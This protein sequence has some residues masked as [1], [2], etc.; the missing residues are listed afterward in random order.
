MSEKMPQQMMQEAVTAANMIYDLLAQQTWKN[1]RWM[2]VT[3]YKY[4]TDLWV[5]QEIMHE[6]RPTLIVETGTAHGGSALFF[7]DVGSL[8]GGGGRPRRHRRHR[9]HQAR[10]GAP[11]AR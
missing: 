7:A 11:A 5:Y 1:T 2:G 6:T 8:L 10:G 3:L 9:Q 4:A